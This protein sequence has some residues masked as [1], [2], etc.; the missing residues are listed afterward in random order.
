MACKETIH[1]VSQSNWLIW[2][3]KKTL[4]QLQLLQENFTA[5]TIVRYIK[6][7]DLH[8]CRYRK[9]C[10]IDKTGLNNNAFEITMFLN[11]N[12]LAYDR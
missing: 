12:F 5:T 2:N 10:G 6:L 4:K 7:P 8:V 11:K 3:N 1:S 9:L